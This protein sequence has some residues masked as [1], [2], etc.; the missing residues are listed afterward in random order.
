MRLGSQS[1]SRS[2]SGS[3]EPMARHGPGCGAAGAVVQARAKHERV[4]LKAVPTGGGGQPWLRPPSRAVWGR[5]Q[6][7][8]ALWLSS[9]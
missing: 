2:R 4:N 9:P 6:P 7:A 5:G 8:A 3:V 1:V